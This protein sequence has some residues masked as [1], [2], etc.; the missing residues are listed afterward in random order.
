[1]IQCLLTYLVTVAYLGFRKRVQV[2]E[3]PN[4]LRGLYVLG[5]GASFPENCEILL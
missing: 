5:G 1:M 2:S 4:A 3:M